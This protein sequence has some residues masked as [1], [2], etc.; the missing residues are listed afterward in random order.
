[1]RGFLARIRARAAGFE[2]KSLLV[3]KD[4]EAEG[5]GHAMDHVGDGGL[6]E[7]VQEGGIGGS[8]ELIDM[9]LKYAALVEGLEAD[10]CWERARAERAEEQTDAAEAGMTRMRRELNAFE[11]R[12]EELEDENL[13]LRE[14]N[15]RL[16]AEIAA[17]GGGRRGSMELDSSTS[18]GV[19]HREAAAV[20]ESE[21]LKRHIEGLSRQ[22]GRLTQLLGGRM[23]ASGASSPDQVSYMAKSSSSNVGGGNPTPPRS[24]IASRSLVSISPQSAMSSSREGSPSPGSS[25]PTSVAST[26]RDKGQTYAPHSPVSLQLST[27]PSPRH[28]FPASTP[29]SNPSTSFS[30]RASP[31]ANNTSSRNN[32]GSSNNNSDG[33]GGGGVGGAIGGFFGF[34]SSSKQSS[35]TTSM[36]RRSASTAPSTLSS[37]LGPINTLTDENSGPS[38]NPLDASPA[39]AGASA[40]SIK[41]RLLSLG[42]SSIGVAGSS[43]TPQRSALSERRSNT[44]AGM[45]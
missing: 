13:A 31:S 17:A 35:S 10:L 12:M 28:G 2:A 41:E 34:G 22:R 21:E 18:G 7:N 4:V 27:S 45:R 1:M 39:R 38:S 44:M 6:Q 32:S 42:K 43:K 8:Q 25:S 11:R 3:L 23:R 36:S 37:A 15:A 29:S 19:S 14:A 9:Q 5:G 20:V 33:G 40:I 26:R 30:R 24:H 16:E